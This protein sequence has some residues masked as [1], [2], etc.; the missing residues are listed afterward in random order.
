MIA[1]LPMVA[2]AG[3]SPTA[4]TALSKNAPEGCAFEYSGHTLGF[5]TADDKLVGA[6]NGCIAATTG[7]DFGN[8]VDNPN[9][10][11]TFNIP[12]GGADGNGGMFRLSAQQSALQLNVVALPGEKNAVGAFVRVTLL[13]ENYAPWV[14]YA[15]LNWRGLSMGYGYTLFSD[16]RCAPPTLDFKGPCAYTGVSNAVVQYRCNLGSGFSAGGA[17]ELPML[18]ATYGEKTAEVSQRFPDIP[19]MVC[20][21]YGGGHVRFSALLRNMQYRDLVAARNRDCVGWGVQLS[22]ANT[23]LPNLS[24]FWQGA[25]GRG[26]ASYIQ[27]LNGGGLDLTPAGDGRMRA[28]EVWGAFAGLQYNFSKCLCGCIACSQLG[29]HLKSYHGGKC[30]YEDQPAYTQYAVCNL[31][32]Q[33]ND[34]VC[35]GVEYIYGRRVNTNHRQGHASRLQTM[36]KFSF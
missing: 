9:E 16:A 20:Y 24:A 31:T 3:L 34:F 19:A 7:L 30:P 35:W 12:V 18:S 36:L 2:Q 25:Y 11:T 1:S 10:F 5:N 15:L 13:G 22:G 17:F 6:F 14:E 26:M 32:W 33:V 28:T 8:I 4:A 23:I 27:D 29:T 21:D